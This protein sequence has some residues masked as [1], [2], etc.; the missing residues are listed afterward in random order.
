MKLLVLNNYKYFKTIKKIRVDDS[1]PTYTNKKVS[2]L[3]NNQ[4]NRNTTPKDVVKIP[5]SFINCFIG[6]GSLFSH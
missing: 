4:Y 2:N 3:D 6:G 1:P 5:N